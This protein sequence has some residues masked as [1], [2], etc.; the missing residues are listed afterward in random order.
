MTKA[1]LFIALALCLGTGPAAA[2]TIRNGE[3]GFTLGL[4]EGAREFPEGRQGPDMIWSYVIGPR[5]DEGHVLGFTV[6]RMRGTIGREKW[7]MQEFNQQR[8]RMKDHPIVKLIPPDAKVE[9][10]NEAWQSFEI[11]VLR[12]EF[13]FQGVAMVSYVAQVPLRREAI[14]ISVAS[15]QDNAEEGHRLLRTLLANLEG[16]S[17]WTSGGGVLPSGRL[18]ETER[19]SRLFTGIGKMVGVIVV[20]LLIARTVSRRSRRRRATRGAVPPPPPP[21]NPG[22]PLPP[23]QY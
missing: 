18:T 4:P 14:Q 6:E 7:T 8:E 16:E 11:Q 17:N 9:I 15:G 23:V 20:V 5:V 12:M 1:P 13:T 22:G 3:I 21:Y 19:W 10:I 2:E